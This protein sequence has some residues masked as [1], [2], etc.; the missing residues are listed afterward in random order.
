VLDLQKRPGFIPGLRFYYGAL[1]EICS[2]SSPGTGIPHWRRQLH[3]PKLIEILNAPCRG[4]FST[5]NFFSGAGASEIDHLWLD[6][7]IGLG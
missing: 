2:T 4:I 7:G 5:D 3:D 1:A 6:V